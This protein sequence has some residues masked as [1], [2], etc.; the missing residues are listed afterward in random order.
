[1]SLANQYELQMLALINDERTSR[2]LNPLQLEQ[3]L[4]TAAETHSQW[5]LDV[6]QFSHTGNAGSSAG[7]RMRSAGFEFEGNWA[8]AENIAWQSERGSGGIEDDVINLHNSLMNSSG[9]RANILNPNLV[10]IGIG[11]EEGEFDGY[12]A[13]MVTQNF[14]TTT[15][16]VSLDPQTGDEPDP[17]PTPDPVTVFLTRGDDSIA[18]ETSSHVR[19]RAG[20][21]TVFGS[22]GEDVMLGGRGADDLSGGGG[23]DELRGGAQLDNLSGGGGSDTLFGD[24]GADMLFGNDDDD[25]LIGGNGRDT[26]DGG[27]GNDVIQGGKGTDT[28]VF[29]KG[30]D[31]ALDF[32]SAAGDI[33]D[34]SAAIGI[35]DLADL[36]E[37]HVEQEGSSVKI[38]DDAGNALVL[39]R[40]DLTM[41]ETTDILI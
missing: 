2:G 19:A 24:N 32:D 38:E 41:L 15:A 20:D 30:V 40:F 23:A 10:Y 22:E 16:S 26:L 37:N 5:M 28:F 25:L 21:D 14:A 17:V 7:D 39:Q 6:D 12:S 8:N 11:I 9:H 4:N 29:S 3:N 35:D 27:A 34:L 13:V 18:L 36:I 1:M 31:Q 33:L